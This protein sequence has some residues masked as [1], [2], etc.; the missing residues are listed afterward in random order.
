MKTTI[1][2]VSQFRDAFHAAGRS[3]QF[4]YEGLEILFNYSE[5]V[6]PDYELDVVALCCDYS[7]D[8]VETIARDYSIDL[9]DADP[10]ADDYEDQ[11]RQIV[12][13]YLNNNCSVVGVTPS[14][15]IVY[16]QF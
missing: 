10:E 12:F 1:D 13:D 11:C 16:A 7:E 3:S 5:E 14:G 2:N 8:D 9:N 4:S 15:L 6:N